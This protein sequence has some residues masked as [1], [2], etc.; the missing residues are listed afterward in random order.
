[1]DGMCPYV[2]RCACAL[3]TDTPR[4]MLVDADSYLYKV[5]RA[6]S[7]QEFYETWSSGLLAPGMESTEMMHRLA[8]QRAPAQQKTGAAAPR[9]SVRTVYRVRQPFVMAVL[10]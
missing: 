3:Q 2:R 8:I 7:D 9:A 5:A 1:M 10:V 6:I 4:A